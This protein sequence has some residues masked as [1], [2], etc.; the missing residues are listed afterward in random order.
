MNGWHLAWRSA[1]SFGLRL[2]RRICDLCDRRLGIARA[3]KLQDGYEVYEHK[4][5]HGTALEAFS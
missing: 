3:L 5:V 1:F 2:G 4:D